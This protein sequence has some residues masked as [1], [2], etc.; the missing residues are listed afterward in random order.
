MELES[1]IP[2]TPTGSDGTGLKSGAKDVWIR[3][4]LYKRTMI[5]AIFYI[6]R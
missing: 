6:V 4:G 3:S 5:V 1:L 2:A